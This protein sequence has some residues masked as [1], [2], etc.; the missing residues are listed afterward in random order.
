MSSSNDKDLKVDI[1]KYN[2]SMSQK[3]DSLNEVQKHWLKM[4]RDTHIPFIIRNL[5]KKKE[6]ERRGIEGIKKW[7][8]YTKKLKAEQYGEYT[9]LID[10][11]KQAKH[12]M[13]Q[14]VG[15]IA[16]KVTYLYIKPIFSDIKFEFQ[17]RDLIVKPPQ[18]RIFE[19]EGFLDK[20]KTLSDN[21]SNHSSSYD[22]SWSYDE[23]QRQV[24][25]LFAPYK[26]SNASNEPSSQNGDCNMNTLHN[27][28]KFAYHY[29]NP[30]NKGIHGLGLI[31]AAGSGK[32]IAATMVTSIFARAGR[33][34]LFIVPDSKATRGNNDYL[35][36]CFL[37]LADVNIQQFLAKLSPKERK[38]PMT[39][40]DAYNMHQMIQNRH[41]SSKA[42]VELT[43]AD[44]LE[45]S[46]KY[47]EL[48]EFGIEMWKTMG[49]H[50]AWKKN[51]S[52]SNNTSLTKFSKLTNMMNDVYKKQK[53]GNG[54]KGF[55]D[56]FQ[57]SICPDQD[58][59]QEFLVI[60]DEAHDLVPA[61]CNDNTPNIVMMQECFWRSHEFHQKQLA[62]QINENESEPK[63]S[64]KVL[65]LTATPVA[66][67]PIDLINL[68]NLLVE[69]KQGIML[70]DEKD[71][72][73]AASLSKVNW[74]HQYKV[75]RDKM[76]KTFDDVFTI[77][78]LQKNPPIYQFDQEYKI[79]KLLK[80]VISYLNPQGNINSF[81]RP[82][83][84]FT[85]GP[86]NINQP[87]YLNIRLTHG[88]QSDVLHCFKEYAQIEY[89]NGEWKSIETKTDTKS[90]TKSRSIPY[91]NP[92]T[93]EEMYDEEDDGIDDDDFDDDDNFFENETN[94][95]LKPI[96]NK[97]MTKLQQC[98]S[99]AMLINGMEGKTSRNVLRAIKGMLRRVP[100]FERKRQEIN[101]Y[102]QVLSWLCGRVKDCMEQDVRMS[103]TKKQTIF[104]D[105]FHANSHTKPHV[106]I[107][108][109]NIL[110][111]TLQ[112][113]TINYKRG[114]TSLHSSGRLPTEEKKWKAIL[115]GE[116]KYIRKLE[117]YQ[118][119]I[120]LKNS[121]DPEL[122]KYNKFLINIFNHKDNSDGKYI[123]F[124]L[125][126]GDYITGHSF[127]DV[128]HVHIVGLLQSEADLRQAIARNIRFLGHCNSQFTELGWP[129]QIFIYRLMFNGEYDNMGQ[130]KKGIQDLLEELQGVTNKQQK[131]N[132]MYELIRECAVDKELNQ[133]I[134]DVSDQITNSYQLVSPEFRK[135][136]YQNIKA[137]NESFLDP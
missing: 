60:I 72:K 127:R 118:N 87:M 79:K 117:A 18:R 111:Y 97:K 81:A 90:N 116:K 80:G 38:E 129:I 69:R 44:V 46:I 130:T 101:E 8:E 9:R 109:A 98:V 126:D 65:L 62:D 35:K 51:T 19:L 92:F 26:W 123:R 39:M 70:L 91:K 76:I 7:R 110:E 104:A 58:L 95:K 114:G 33:K 37:K 107:L 56:S 29:F 68:A 108:L 61:I 115:T 137:L 15:P 84:F 17:V 100:G 71:W 67:H 89:K 74:K 112:L 125:Y 66:N 32:S 52:N 82:V 42:P 30:F 2:L 85:D 22:I 86:K 16:N 94:D 5:D 20:M 128:G 43:M 93:G 96:N 57:K 34:L 6:C 134:N 53:L 24:A 120:I 132:R 48:E 3:L 78:R 40:I 13:Y 41:S 135:E 49:I 10:H 27:S 75:Y 23:I 25:H 119:M 31:H 113:H 45:D 105:H 14:D 121:Q 136:K 124:L 99:R 11:I 73:T 64:V 77:R 1:E 133:S 103:N 106:L 63:A 36:E 4:L 83:N 21:L 47:R 59:L 55:W 131:I 12:K 102:S 50:Y 122:E 28:Q 54:A 88:Q